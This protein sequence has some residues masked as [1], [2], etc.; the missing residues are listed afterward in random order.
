MTILELTIWINDTPGEE[1]LSA[2]IGASCPEVGSEREDLL[3]QTILRECCKVIIDRCDLD[4]SKIKSALKKYGNKTA[5][6]FPEDFLRK[7]IKN[8]D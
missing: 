8:H 1:K 7:L 5:D 2:A 4:N 3:G 6:I